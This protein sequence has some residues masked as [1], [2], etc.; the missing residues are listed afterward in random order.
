MK[1]IDR[2]H[3][4]VTRQLA[5]MECAQYEIGIFDSRTDKMYLRVW[6]AAMIFKSLDYLKRM[7]Y[8]GHN[9]FIRPF[10]ITGL[11]FFDD[12]D[13]AKLGRLIADGLEPALIIQSSPLNYHGWIRI[14]AEPLDEQLCTHA[15]KVV[16]KKY[17][18]DD[19]AAKWRQFGRLA[20]FTN[21]KPK[22]VDETGK[23][24]Y[25]LL[26]EA[27]GALASKS[28]QLISDA[29]LSLQAAE[30][31]RKKRIEIFKSIVPNENLTDGERFF[32]S[33]LSGLLKRYG[34]NLD[35]SRADWVIVNKMLLRGYCPEAVQVALLEH[36][37][38]VVDRSGRSALSYVEIT[39]NSAL[40]LKNK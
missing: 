9:I 6:D 29:A 34:A 33:E 31:E 15:C 13:R 17:G 37:L 28:E 12:F 5:V 11:I 10:G 2:T 8:Q 23:Y 7:N 30:D 22:Y 20:G 19:G 35:Y 1:G 27:K 3:V 4:A 39:I 26:D 18:G 16:S 25:V 24:P 40:G 21:R 38:H 14:S 32:V 36:S